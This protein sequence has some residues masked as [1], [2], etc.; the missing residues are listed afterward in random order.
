MSY[1]NYT[2]HMA[3]LWLHKYSGAS[4]TALPR[5]HFKECEIPCDKHKNDLWRVQF[6]VQI[7]ETPGWTSGYDSR[8]LRNAGTYPNYT[9]PHIWRPNL[10]FRE[11]VRARGRAVT[12]QWHEEWISIMTGNRTTRCTL[13]AP[14]PK[15]TVHATADCL[16]SNHTN[17]A[18]EGLPHTVTR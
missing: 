5:T 13:Q 3:V 17:N 18:L 15:S 14:C 7:Q 12:K 10:N 11:S 2:L 1:K 4:S 6:R 16:L 9:T 8:F